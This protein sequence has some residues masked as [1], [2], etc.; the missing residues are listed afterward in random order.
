MY[1][2]IKRI[3]KRVV[4]DAYPIGIEKM[5]IATDV[6]EKNKN[7]PLI[8]LRAKTLDAYVTRMPIAI[9]DDELL[10][11]IAA[12]KPM[13]LEIDP[14][15]GIWPQDEIDS[16]KEDGYLIDPQ[17][18]I[19]LQ[20]LNRRHQPNT[21]I[22]QMGEIIYENPRL[23]NMLKAG[24]I[25]PPWKDKSAGKGVGGGYCQSGLGLGP[26]LYLL[27]VDYRKI[28]H[29]GTDALVEQCK[30][31][32]DKLNF[33]DAE[34]VEKFRFYQAGIICLNAVKKLGLRYSELAAEMAAKESDPVRK[35]ELEQISEI[36]A[37]VPGKPARTFRE[38]MQAFWF[39]FIM[40]SPATT[41][42]GDRFDQIMYPYYKADLDAGRITPEEATELLCLLR[43][44]DMELNRT[45][46]KNNRKKNAGMAKWHNFVIGGQTP[47]GK[48]A[49]NDISYMMLDA[50]MITMVPQ[51]TIT[52]RVWEGTP[53]SLMKKALEC[54]RTGLGMPAFVGDKSYIATFTTRGIPIEEA[55]NYMLCGCLDGNLGNGK[56]RVGPVPMVTIPLL[57]DMFRHNGKDLATGGQCTPDPGNF[58]DYKTY[59]ELWNAW[60]KHLKYCM[61]IVGEKNNIELKITQ[62]ILVD[63]LRSVLMHEGI[64]SG[65]DTF[66]RKMYF[67][68]GAVIN[69]IG[70]INMGDSLAAIKKLVFDEKKYT[71]AQ[72]GEALDANW[73]GYDEM[74][75][76]F[77]AAPKYGN[78]ID[79]VD[80]IVAECYKTLY[81]MIEEIPTIL[82]GK[83]I[84]TGI[85]ITSHQ[86]G[87]LLTGATPDGRKAGEILAD[88]TV[89][90]MQGMDNNGPT[91]VMKS[92]LKINQDPAMATLMNMKFSPTSLKTD[93]DL[94]KLAALIRTYLLN[95]G[96][97]VQFNVVD[98]STLRAAQDDPAKYRE[99]VVRIAGYSCYFVQ[100]NNAMQ[101]EVIARN[102]Q[103]L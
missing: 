53:D 13:G 81:A 60:L 4:I 41:L 100:L 59:D 52:V 28:I 5:R 22:G 9:A 101:N 88:G 33:C 15:Y 79:Y 31:Y 75:K 37:Q 64:E 27:G 83:T 98:T 1:E 35:A 12:S 54:V 40:L 55:R 14:D 3:K 65:K 17:D 102:E 87:G 78:D 62:E 47:D 6:R 8:L 39:E 70:M 36:C 74:R 66:R 67:E 77:L 61:E 56:S 76:D 25:L 48:D 89:S 49:T 23:I 43:L 63:P 103:K 7:D 92:A 57:F 18:E 73:E 20:E 68:N 85:S 30:E 82:G 58:A 86:P 11:G 93:A 45:S 26:S 46:G 84:P 91:A 42:P 71:L 10:V 32:M 96:K 29:Y 72:L 44:K 51:H 69:P 50:A 80:N 19:D 99:L 38:A 34:A 2:R 16:L 21:L 24:I 94:M 90:P 97:H 95:G